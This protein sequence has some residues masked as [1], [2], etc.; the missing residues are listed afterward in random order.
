LE[1]ST[2][3]L[4]ELNHYDLTFFND[5][6]IMA[7]RKDNPIMTIDD[8]LTYYKTVKT[9]NE[10]LG[11]EVNAKTSMYSEFLRNLLLPSLNIWKNMYS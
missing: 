10:R 8:M 2:Q 6:D 3:G 11:T 7:D 1:K 9:E 4:K 5:S